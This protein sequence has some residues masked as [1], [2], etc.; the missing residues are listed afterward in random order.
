MDLMKIL[1]LCIIFLMFL[2][3]YL[4]K[5][6]HEGY[7]RTCI[8]IYRWQYK[9][10]DPSSTVTNMPTLNSFSQSRVG[11]ELVFSQI[12][13]GEFAFREHFLD[14]LHRI[15]VIRCLPIMYGDIIIDPYQH[16]MAVFGRLYWYAILLPVFAAMHFAT[17]PT[18][19]DLSLPILL[20]LVLVYKNSFSRHKEHLRKIVEFFESQNM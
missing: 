10:I 14:M 1:N 6:G 13:A 18:D 12:K 17:S 11:K 9:S 20:V 2:E 19:S 4:V 7:I 5:A 8:Q 16:A 15:F 3:F